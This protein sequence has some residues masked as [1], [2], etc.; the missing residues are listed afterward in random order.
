[1]SGKTFYHQRFG[2]KKNSYLNQ[3]I[4]LPS[5]SLVNWSTPN[6]CIA[7]TRTLSSVYLSY[8]HTAP[9]K[10]STDRK[11]ARLL[12]VPFPLK[13][14]LTVQKFKCLAVQSSVWTE[15]KH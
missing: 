14:T 15:R 11:F 13:T 4:H 3:I 1:M 8:V 6:M 9:V 10:F 7:G 5:P 2:K 12:V